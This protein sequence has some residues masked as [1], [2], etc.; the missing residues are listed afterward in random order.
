MPVISGYDIINYIK[1]NKWKLPKVIVVSA[2]ILEHEKNKCKQLGIDY[3][4]PKPVNMT[5]L[6]KAILNVS[7][8]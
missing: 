6:K 5:D 3:F 4:I 2:S 8:I 1:E 7:K